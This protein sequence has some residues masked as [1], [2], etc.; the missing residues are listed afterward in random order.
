MS[1]R[2][3]GDLRPVEALLRRMDQSVRDAASV[4]P[5]D[6]K[7]EVLRIVRGWISDALDEARSPDAEITVEE[8]AA[9]EG[10]SVQA[11]YKRRQRGKLP[12]AR[13][14]NGRLYVPVSGVAA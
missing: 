4:Q 1:E 13:K 3:V 7:L 9:L 6:P 10:V 14:R 8:L 11:I 5:S 12:G 2:E